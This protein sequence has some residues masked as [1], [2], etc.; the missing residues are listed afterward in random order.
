MG[1]LE[2]MYPHTLTVWR[3]TPEGRKVSWENLGQ[4]RCRWEERHGSHRSPSGDVADYSALILIPCPLPTPPLL[5]GD[6]VTLEAS[7]DS[8]PPADALAVTTVAPYSVGVSTP[9]HWEATAE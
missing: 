6:R 7:W 5:Q 9:D 4:I 1:L 2:C 8:T 3:K